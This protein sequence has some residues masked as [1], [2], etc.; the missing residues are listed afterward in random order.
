MEKKTG[1]GDITE[2]SSAYLSLDHARTLSPH[3]LNGLLNINL[4][5]PAWRKSGKGREERRKE[6][7]RA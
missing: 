1:L 2:S 5:V 3:Q 7:N 4:I 6:N